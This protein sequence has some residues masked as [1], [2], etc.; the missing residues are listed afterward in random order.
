MSHPSA[1]ILDECHR[2]RGVNEPGHPAMTKTGESKNFKVLVTGGAGFIGSAVIRYLLEQPQ[3]SVVNVD[4][5]TYAGN[6]DSFS[7]VSASPRYS[8]VEADICDRAALRRVLAEHAPDAIMNL[9]AESHVDRSIDSP[10][11]FLQTNLVGTGRLLQAVLA[12]WLEQDEASARP[13]AF[14]MSRPM[15]FTGI[16]R[17][18][19]RRFGR[20]MRTRQ[21]RRMPPPKP[22]PT[23]WSEL[24]GAP[25]S[26]RCC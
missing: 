19:T 22:G 14:Y 3:V 21:A 25:T 6:L 10:D 18:P 26:F 20:P 17:R 12:Y 24:G 8:F 16:W 13:F 23:T 5:L 2:M 15:R 9:A 1:P 11:A 4:K 7:T